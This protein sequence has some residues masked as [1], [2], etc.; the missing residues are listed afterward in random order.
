[1]CFILSPLEKLAVRLREGGLTPVQRLGICVGVEIGV[2]ECVDIVKA[3]VYYGLVVDNV[4]CRYRNVA[5]SRFYVKGG[6]F[7]RKRYRGRGCAQT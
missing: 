1:M 3:Y 6:V 4:L 2:E 7:M 5:L